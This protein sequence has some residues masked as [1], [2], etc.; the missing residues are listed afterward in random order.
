[1]DNLCLP[2]SQRLHQPSM[3]IPSS[4]PLTDLGVVLLCNFGYSLTKTAYKG[5]HGMITPLKKEPHT[6][7]S[8][9]WRWLLQPVITSPRIKL[10][11][12]DGR[13]KRSERSKDRAQTLCLECNLLIVQGNG[14]RFS[15]IL[16][17]DSSLTYS[18]GKPGGSLSRR[19]S[20]VSTLFFANILTILTL[21]V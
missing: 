13:A 18:Q 3:A 16:L 17:P 20:L 15:L 8:H 1:M 21:Q 6:G 14:S 4:L 11:L 9:V 5:F 12:M 10:T 2:K 19:S 7:N